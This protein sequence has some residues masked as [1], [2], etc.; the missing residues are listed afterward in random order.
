MHKTEKKLFRTWQYKV[1]FGTLFGYTA[2]NM[3]RV[4]LAMAMPYLKEE[5]QLTNAEVG[6]IFSGFTFAY[7]MGRLVNGFLSDKSNARYFLTF[8]LV[9]CAALNLCFL[10]VHS[11]LGFFVLW[12]MNGWFQTMGGPASS[13]MLT[14]WFPPHKMGTKWAIWSMSNPIGGGIT[15]MLTGSLVAL[16]GWKMAF[17]APALVACLLVPFL[18]MVLRDRPEDVFAAADTEE[19]VSTEDVVDDDRHWTTKEIFQQV[20]SNKNLW[21]ICLASFSLYCVRTGF[22][23]W[24]PLILKEMRGFDPKTI[25]A[26]G[27]I[28]EMGGLAGGLIAGW[29]SDKIF[30]GRR[31]PV[32]FFYMGMLTLVIYA[33]WALPVISQWVDMLLMVLFGFF[34]FGPQVLVGVAAADFATK[35]AVG[36]GTGLVGSCGYL[37][38]TLSGFGIGYVI[39]YFGGWHAGFLCFAGVAA[40]GS[41]AFALTVVNLRDAT[42]SL[43]S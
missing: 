36:V 14:H 1:L 5:F 17:V 18:L 39:D 43:T 28:F 15:F 31:G 8:G 21:F 7:A 4:N 37:G 12:M 22:L 3:L 20:L 10:G 19:A 35:K 9:I 6:W 42:R 23:N 25:G 2:F 30:T 32:G 41:I 34:A 33:F 38:A 24:C 13:R 27:F 29:A 40:L 16:L 26:M 11:Y